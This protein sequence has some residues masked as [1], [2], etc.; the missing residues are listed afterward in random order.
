MSWICYIHSK[1]QQNAVLK[2]RTEE[3]VLLLALDCKVGFFYL[4]Y[5]HEFENIYS[6][7]L[8]LFIYLTALP[9]RQ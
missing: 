9:Q 3:R 1:V 7:C 8:N 6:K 2:H 5:M 4:E